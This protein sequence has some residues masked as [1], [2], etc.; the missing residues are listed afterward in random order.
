MPIHVPKNQFFLI[1]PDGAREVSE[2]S[3]RAKCE[4]L[5]LRCDKCGAP[6]LHFCGCHPLGICEKC[7]CHPLEDVLGLERLCSECD[8]ERIAELYEEDAALPRAHWLPPHACG[9]T[10]VD[11]SEGLAADG[12]VRAAFCTGCEQLRRRP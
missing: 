7:K 6:D 10:E 9:A 1:G 2:E 3:F 8:H 12:E 4:R 11:L 5:A